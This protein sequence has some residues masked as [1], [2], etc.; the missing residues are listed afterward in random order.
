MLRVQETQAVKV[1]RFWRPE[2][3]SRDAGYRAG[4][5]DV[6]AGDETSDVDFDDII[7]PCTV[8]PVGSAGGR[9]IH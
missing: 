4:F 7:G 9:R 6:Y 1:Q 3:I 5:W 8:L 2:D